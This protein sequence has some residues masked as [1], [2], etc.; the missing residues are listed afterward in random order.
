[1][2]GTIG[3]ME[4]PFGKILTV[5][6]GPTRIVGECTEK[7]DEGMF[8]IKD[9]GSDKKFYFVLPRAEILVIHN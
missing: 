8:V 4:N 5:Q 6:T 3:E 7:N 2:P 1:M 9:L